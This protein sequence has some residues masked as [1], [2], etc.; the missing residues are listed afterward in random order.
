[1]KKITD[2]VYIYPGETTVGLITKDKVGLLIDS[3]RES[4]VKK[5]LNFAKKKGIEIVGVLTTHSHADH[6]GGHR[7]LHERGVKIFAPFQEEAMI[8]YPIL[9]PMGTSHG[10]YPF[11]F[12]QNQYLMVDKPTPVDEVLELGEHEKFGL[13]FCLEDLSG[14]TLGQVGISYGDVFFIADS[15]FCPRRMAKH[16]IPF[17]KCIKK[18]LKTLDYL[19][20]TDYKI[21]VPSHGDPLSRDEMLEKVDLNRKI[22]LELENEILEFLESPREIFEVYDHIFIQRNLNPPNGSLYFLLQNTIL[23]YMSHL[24]RDGY[25]KAE[26]RNGRLYWVRVV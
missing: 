26:A 18:E 7:Y 5:I 25:V 8:K 20:K 21:Y 2:R 14:H 13:K 12:L 11:S 24:E 17:H 10:I 9:G 22:I 6:F 3:H 15:L 4:T 23:S 19:E 16:K 1:M